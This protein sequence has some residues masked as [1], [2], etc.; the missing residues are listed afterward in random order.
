MLFGYIVFIN[1]VNK[2]FGVGVF[3][4]LYRN[5]WCINSGEMDVC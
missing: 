1:Y 2:M 5:N 4:G 3:K